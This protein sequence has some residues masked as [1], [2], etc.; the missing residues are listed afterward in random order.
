MHYITPCNTSAKFTLHEA[1]F[2]TG[3]LKGVLFMPTD[4]P[5]FP[6]SILNNLSEMNLSEIGYLVLAAL[7]G[8]DIPP[9]VIKSVV[10][11]SL[12][13]ELPLKN[14]A[15]NFFVVDFSHGPTGSRYDFSAL[16]FS[17]LLK[18][19]QR[20]YSPRHKLNILAPGIFGNGFALT[21]ALMPLESINLFVFYP[22]SDR[23]EAETLL[24]TFHDNGLETV[25]AGQN[26]EDVYSV[27]QDFFTNPQAD[28]LEV[29]I[30]DI[31]NIAFLLPLVVPVFAIFAQLKRFNRNINSFKLLTSARTFG[32]Y[33]AARIAN[34]MGLPVDC[35]LTDADGKK[36]FSSPH[37]NFMQRFLPDESLENLIIPFN[38]AVESAT[39]DSPVV[40]IIDEENIKS[41]AKKNVSSKK[42]KTYNSL[43]SLFR[44]IES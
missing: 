31:T 3:G 11:E 18:Y 20:G 33:I 12:T 29:V 36:A 23:K 2:G 40:S 37:H 28:K 17:L 1:V 13:F 30:G 8:K 5:V 41:S 35:I 9:S 34:K 14:K 10:N 27:L 19:C 24:H 15:E 7:L 22:E 21:R 39:A 32:L 25:L 26:W 42:P 6:R 38:Q 16:P 43:S 4:L 44:L